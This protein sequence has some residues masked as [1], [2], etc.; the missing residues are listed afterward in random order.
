VTVTYILQIIPVTVGQSCFNIT[1]R[2]RRIATRNI[3]WVISALRFHSGR[4]LMVI[5]VWT[6]S[7]VQNWA[8]LPKFMINTLPAV[9]GHVACVATNIYGICSEI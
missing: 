2:V 9:R 1:L 6:D 4:L 8:I 3:Y 5:V 7:T